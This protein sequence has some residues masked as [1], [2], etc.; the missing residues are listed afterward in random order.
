MLLYVDD[1]L[2]ISESPKEAV[3]QLDKFF[4]MQPSSIAPLNIYLRGK[5]Q[6]MRLPNMLEAWTF[7]SS[8]YV[9]E[10]VYNVEKFL[11]DLDVSM[12]SMNI[13]AL[14]SNGYRPKLDISPELDGSDGGY[15]QSLIGIIW[16]MVELG[17]IDICC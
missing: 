1:C 2:A 10:T 3:F 5:V 9:Q 11:Q 16:W 12:L 7:I 8:Q 6:K 13:N 14:L 15:Y 17:I 4:K